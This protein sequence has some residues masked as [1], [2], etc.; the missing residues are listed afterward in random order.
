MVMKFF[1]SGQIDDADNIK[2]ILAKVKKAGHTITHDWTAT[3]TFL[4]SAQDKLSNLGESQVRAKNDIDGVI[5]CDV[6]VLSSD[7]QNVGKGMY[8]ELGAAIALSETT[9]TPKIY[10]I[11]ELNHL[12]LFYLHP[13]VTLKKNIQEVLEDL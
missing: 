11:G 7:N 3:D 1:I 5:N 10:V 13:S 2:T 6:Y 9:G 12:S 4:G 8:V